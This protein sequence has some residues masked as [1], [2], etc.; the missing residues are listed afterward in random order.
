MVRLLPGKQHKQHETLMTVE[1]NNKHTNN[2]REKMS[3]TY[4]P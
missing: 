3:M 4:H 1:V 2:L